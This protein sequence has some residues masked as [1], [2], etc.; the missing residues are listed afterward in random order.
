MN[1][2]FYIILML[3]LAFFLLGFI[4]TIFMDFQGIMGNEKET[5]THVEDD[6]NVDIVDIAEDHEEETLEEAKISNIR[7]LAVG[8]L[9]FHSPQYKAAFDNETK[10]YDFTPTFK[11]VKK[12][13]E[14]AD[15]A[16]GNFETVTGGDEIGYS[17]Y[18]RFNTPEAALFAIKEAG[19]DILSTA[20]NHS[21]DQGKKGL[22]NTIDNIHKYGMKN[23]GTYKEENS[24]LVEEI[25][26]IKIGF[27]SY[28]YG[29]NGMDYTLTEEEL[30]YMVNLIDEDRIKSQIQEARA[31]D[32]DLI[33]VFIH[34]G[35]EYQ[36]EP[37]TYQLVLGEKIIE[38]GGDIILGS[39]PHVVQKSQIINKEGKDKFI[40]YSMGNFL[41]N[42]RRETMGNSYTE[43]GIMVELEIEKNLTENS[44]IIKNIHY[45][46]TWVHRYRDNGRLVYEIL[47]IE[48]YLKGDIQI[49]DDHILRDRLE[50]SFNDT[51]E[52]MIENST[53]SEL[54]QY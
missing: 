20:N 42:Q 7:I 3:V 28:T 33:V 53:I 26:Q 52:N 29:L 8:D 44:T 40:I 13:I 49:G 4:S 38:W 30:T 41:S 12:Y 25:N 18:P 5:Y 27:L 39:H 37:S 48:D 24:I 47:P 45:I 6:E 36:R 2:K 35:N 10:E 17:G 54:N 32:L 16:L 31:M 21:L 23:I 34:W 11:Y 1:R 46:P 14:S 22:V 9:M 51:M 43:D 19:F 50:K 15:L